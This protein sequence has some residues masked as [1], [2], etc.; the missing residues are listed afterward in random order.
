MPVIIVQHNGVPVSIEVSENSLPGISAY[1]VAVNNGFIGDEA[2]WLE[3][4]R[5]KSAYEIAVLNGYQGTLP[6]WIASLKGEKGDPF[7]YANF[8]AEQIE[9]L[10]VKGDQGIQGIQ[11]IRGI[12]GNQ[13]IQGIKGDQG[14]QGIKGVDFVTT[15]IDNITLLIANWILVSGMYEY[16][17]ANALILADSVVDILPYESSFFAILQ[18]EISP[19][20]VSSVGT[21][22]IKA[23]NLP[24]ANILIAININK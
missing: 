6:E 22:K 13:G 21:L 2:A 15:T 18:A 12:Q 17:Y 20:V 16:N 11:G 7:I 9:L 19:M 4:L 23:K 3:F 1:H 14:I 8:T 10:K 5:G 24:V